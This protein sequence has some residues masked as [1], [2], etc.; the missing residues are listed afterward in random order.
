MLQ[1]VVCMKLQKCCN[2]KYFIPSLYKGEYFI[3]NYNSKCIKFT[4]T[5]HATGEF[6][7]VPI[8]ESR[9]DEELCGKTAKFFEECD[10]NQRSTLRNCEP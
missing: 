4:K 8:S 9:N 5:H 7:Y 3:G 2:C 10:K 1:V 6:D